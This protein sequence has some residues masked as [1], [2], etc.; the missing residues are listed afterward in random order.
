M[1]IAT[2]WL[3]LFSWNAFAQN[4]ENVQ[5]KDPLCTDS[6]EQ[7]SQQL[8]LKRKNH[9]Q[10]QSLRK[11]TAAQTVWFLHV[12]GEMKRICQEDQRFADE[13]R[14]KIW[15]EAVG[16]C[17][18]AAQ[19]ALADQAVLEQ[20]EKSLHS[21]E[22]KREQYLLKGGRQQESLWTIFEKNYARVENDALEL[23]DVPR[24]TMCEIQWLYPKSFL[25]KKPPFSGCPDAP[26]DQERKNEGFYELLMRRHSESTEFRKKRHDIAQK[27]ATASRSRYEA[28]IAKLPDEPNVLASP[29]KATGT[30]ENQPN[31][32]TEK[33]P[34]SDITGIEEE[35]AKRAK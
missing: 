3:F 19:A 31:R 22:G 29:T 20:A 13:L 9:L 32:G 5:E 12:T 26:G 11:V 7:L 8:A 1:R 2:L 35:K 27:A 17:K 18:P 23:G 10:H 15:P 30:K 14:K 21:L 25:D 6:Q 16:Q 34:K 33:K 28:C 4:K 24:V